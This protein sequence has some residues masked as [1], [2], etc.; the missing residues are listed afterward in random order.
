MAVRI[1]LRRMGAKKRPFYRI[2]VVDS[3]TRRDGRF[4][5]MVGYYNPLEKPT[6]IK[7]QEEKV[8]AWLKVGAQPSETVHRLLQ[9]AGVLKKWA[10]LRKGERISPISSPSESFEKR[11]TEEEPEEESET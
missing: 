8:L 4:L 9:K 11:E 1:R 5:E 6:Q 7:I 2:V 3:R 10:L